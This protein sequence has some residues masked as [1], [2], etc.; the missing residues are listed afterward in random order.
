MSNKNKIILIIN[1]LKEYYGFKTNKEFADFLGIA[2][3]T[4][5][6]W[7]SRSTIDY[8]LI[9]SKCV[10]ID[11]N[12]LLTG[13]GEMLR[14]PMEEIGGAPA[15]PP[16]A[17]KDKDPPACPLCA[18]KERVIASMQKQLEDKDKI[19]A[20]LEAQ[21]QECRQLQAKKGGAVVEVSV[22]PAKLKKRV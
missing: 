14:V 10:D 9:Y 13:E 17:K 15:P 2:P 16:P 20:L 19:I 12:W 3:T 22:P 4:L 11:A 6:S 18:E 1:K 7:Y 5:S 21:L 8:N